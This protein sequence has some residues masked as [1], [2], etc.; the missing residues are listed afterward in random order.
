[1]YNTQNLYNTTTQTGAVVVDNTPPS[2]GVPYQ[3]PPGQSVDP[4][5]TL[6]VSQGSSVSVSVNITDPSGVEQATLSY[7]N[8]SGWVNLTMS[9]S[10]GNQYAATIPGQSAGTSVTYYVTATD[11]ALNTGR[12]PADT[13]Y[14]PYN[15]I[16]EFPNFALLLLILAV[17]ATLVVVTSKTTKRKSPPLK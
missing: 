12:T 2:I 16:S 4:S 8:G 9:L 6:N 11:G 13:L 14:Y 3:N 5:V 1:M 17:G 10:T 15:V 7:N